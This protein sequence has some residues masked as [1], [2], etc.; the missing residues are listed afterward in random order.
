M[1]NVGLGVR[2]GEWEEGNVKR[3]MERGEWKVGNRKWELGNEGYEVRNGECGE[4]GNGEWGVESGK[5]RV[6]SGEYC[7][8][9]KRLC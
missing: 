9:W 3:G 8:E 5:S 6:N 7:R 1:R 2:R 4:V